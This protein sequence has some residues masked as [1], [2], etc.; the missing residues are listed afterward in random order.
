MNPD[1]HRGV[2]VTTAQQYQT[3]A[4]LTPLQLF[5]DQ[6]RWSYMSL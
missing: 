2:E 5:I 6:S 3:M 4:R 1:S